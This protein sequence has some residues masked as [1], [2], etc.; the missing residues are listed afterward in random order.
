MLQATAGRGR[1]RSVAHYLRWAAGDQE[2]ACGPISDSSSLRQPSAGRAARLL[3][4]GKDLGLTTRQWRD[5]FA[6]PMH[7]LS[8]AGTGAAGLD[9]VR[10]HSPD[11]IILDLRLAD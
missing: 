10:G 9:H 11:V 2:E 5:A 4:I 1:G 7:Q 6:E 8:F 3:V